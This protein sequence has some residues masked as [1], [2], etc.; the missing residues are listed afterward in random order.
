MERRQPIV[1]EILGLAEDW[2]KTMEMGD[3]TINH[4]FNQYEDEYDEYAKTESN[5]MMHEHDITWN[6]PK[7]E[8]VNVDVET[9]VVHELLHAKMSPIEQEI[10]AE[11][12]NIYEFVVQGIARALVNTRRTT[13]SPYIPELNQPIKKLEDMSDLELRT[14]IT[15][16][17]LHSNDIDDERTILLAEA[18]RRKNG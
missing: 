10:S 2:A 15:L 14:K 1:T 16:C 8:E 3:Q 5:W 7:M 18:E 11:A 13:N 12:D 6:T 9:I 17:N 4:Y